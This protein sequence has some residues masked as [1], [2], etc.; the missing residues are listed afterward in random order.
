VRA[1]LFSGL[2]SH[3]LF[4]DRYGRPG[5][6]NDKGNVE[7]MVGYVRRNHMDTRI[8]ACFSARLAGHDEKLIS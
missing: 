8:N 2:L 1:T 3:Y 6:G 4:R 7:G 5:K